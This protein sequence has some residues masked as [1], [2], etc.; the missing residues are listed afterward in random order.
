MHKCIT[1]KVEGKRNTQKVCK[2]QRNFSKT[3]GIFQSREETG[4]IWRE[5]RN[6]WSMTKNRSSEILA[7]ENRETLFFGKR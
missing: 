1:V 7:D 5:I 3:G 4:K 2:K 6:L